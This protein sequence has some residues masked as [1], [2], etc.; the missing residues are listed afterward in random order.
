MSFSSFSLLCREKKRK[1]KKMK[2]EEERNQHSICVPQK[3]RLNSTSTNSCT[4]P[5]LEAAEEAKPC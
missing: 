5:A 1:S 3:I 4:V 2:T